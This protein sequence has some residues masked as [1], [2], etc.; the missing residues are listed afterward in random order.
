MRDVKGLK[1]MTDAVFIQQVQSDRSNKPADGW[2]ALHGDI[3]ADAP[4]LM[5]LDN[6]SDDGFKARA[7]GHFRSMLASSAKPLIFK[8]IFIDERN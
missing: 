5:R 6:E 2:L 8:P 7:Y 3:P 4:P 1:T